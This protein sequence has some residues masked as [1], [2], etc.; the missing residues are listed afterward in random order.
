MNKTLKTALLVS[1]LALA[2]AF[3][4]Q[5]PAPQQPAP[6]Q[7]AQRMAFRGY[8]VGSLYFAAAQFLGVTPAELALLSGGSK[9]LGQ[10]ATELGKTPAGL[11]AALAAARNQAIDQAVQAG[12][13]STEQANSLKANSQAVARVLVN[14]PV[15]L[16]L[17]P[18][19]RDGRGP[20]GWWR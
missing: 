17:G 14:Q 5:T 1:T 11:E 13:L 9:T 18:A 8:N 19:G 4:Q 10:L 3:A 20:R 15:Q 7:P 6:A 2:G 12:R 16:R